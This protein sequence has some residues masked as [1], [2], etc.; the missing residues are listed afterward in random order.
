VYFVVTGYFRLH[1]CLHSDK[2]H[3]L[4]NKDDVP[5]QA[6]VK[7]KLSLIED[8]AKAIMEGVD[9]NLLRLSES[10]LLA[11]GLGGIDMASSGYGAVETLGTY[12]TPL[13]Q[14]L[15]LI[16]KIV[17]NIADVCLSPF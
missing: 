6:R 3:E 13:G 4:R 8:F 1:S 7:I 2:E 16:V 14:A 12:V 10:R 9:A 17:D 5:I 11:T 15:Q